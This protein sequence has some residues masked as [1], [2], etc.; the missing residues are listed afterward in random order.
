[1]EQDQKK[2]VRQRY[3]VIKQKNMKINKISV[4]NFFAEHFQYPP[5]KLPSHRGVLFAI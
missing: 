4:D 2:N 1:M 5:E 3:V